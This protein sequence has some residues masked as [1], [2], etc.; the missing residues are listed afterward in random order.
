MLPAGRV[1]TMRI[2]KPL[3]SRR[4]AVAAV[5]LLLLLA[6]GALAYAR[7]L[8]P[9]E[10][11]LATAAPGAVEARVSGPGTVQARIPVTLSARV[12][13]SVA[14]MHVD[15]G[16]VVQAGQLL[17]SLDDRDL[18]ARRGIVSGQQDALARNTEA[19]RAA[20]ARARADADLARSRQRRDA[21][22]LAQGFV[23]QAVLDASNAARAAADAALDAAHAALE[24]RAADARVLSQEARYAD[25]M[26]SHARITAPMAALVVQRVAEA[27]STVMPGTPLLKLVDPASLWVATRVDESVV[28]RVRAG[29]AARIR[30][31]T[32]QW[33]TGRVERIARQSDTATREMEVHVGFDG[34]PERFAIDQQAEVHID[35]GTDAGL[36][37]PLGALLRDREGRQGVLVVDAGRARFRRVA[38]A[39]ADARQVL[40]RDG[41]AAGERV[42][43][44]AAG[45]RDGARVRAAPSANAAARREAGSAPWNSP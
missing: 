32:G 7:F 1:L 14:Q 9:V 41:L 45:V 18:L 20:V 8:R 3:S 34:A 43:A 29:Q 33:L 28:G 37:V 35:V 16:D 4:L 25:T 13:A 19:A 40:V 21:E 15:V 31:R 22:L 38:T 17:V 6:A 44:A 23:S 27:G 42:V 30:L 39:G 26:L 10:V 24:A 36:V 2:A 12:T 11:A 5:A